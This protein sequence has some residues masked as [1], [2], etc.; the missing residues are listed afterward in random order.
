VDLA[1]HSERLYPDHEVGG[2]YRTLVQKYV[3]ALKACI[4][5]PEN[6]GDL[7]DGMFEDG[8]QVDKQFLFDHEANRIEKLRKTF[9]K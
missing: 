8:D 9:H 7:Y 5:T 6:P 1:I 3:D 4:G 2:H